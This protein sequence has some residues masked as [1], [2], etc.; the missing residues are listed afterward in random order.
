MRDDDPP[1]DWDHFIAAEAEIKAAAVQLLRAV[2]CGDA[3]A[4][5]E[6]ATRVSGFDDCWNYALEEILRVQPSISPAIRREVLD[7]WAW[8]G[9]VMRCSA[10]GDGL[11]VDAMRHILGHYRGPAR[12][13]YRG[14]RLAA[15]ERGDIGIAWSKHRRVAEWFARWPEG[16]VVLETIA[17]PRAI[18]GRVPS[19]S[20]GGLY[21]G[22]YLVDPRLLES[23]SVVR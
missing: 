7:T 12:R 2:E 4:F 19:W 18:L 10:Y 15:Y 14:E 8:Q 5:R 13:L 11:L 9:R 23:V 20:N 16:G 17:P 1:T 6:A 22:E 3:A 21:L